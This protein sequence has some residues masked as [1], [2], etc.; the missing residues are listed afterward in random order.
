MASHWVWDVAP[1][2]QRG[3]GLGRRGEGGDT[4]LVEV[5]GLSDALEEGLVHHPVAHR[6]PCG[7]VPHMGPRGGEGHGPPPW[8]P[9]RL[10]PQETMW[11]IPS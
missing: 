4:D 1:A 8:T 7:P 3:E 6:H 11:E 10:S 5:E 9:R 2:G